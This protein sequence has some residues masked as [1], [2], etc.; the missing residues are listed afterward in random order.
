MYEL[1]DALGQTEIIDSILDIIKNEEKKYFLL[2]GESGCGKSYL[3]QKLTQKWIKNNPSNSALLFKGDNSFSERYYYPFLNCTLL[4][5]ITFAKKTE[6][7]Q[8]IVEVVKDVPLIGNSLSYVASALAKSSKKVKYESALLFNQTE[9]DIFFKLQYYAQRGKLL[10]VADNFHW[11]D[12]QSISFLKLLCSEE[13][14][15]IYSFLKDTIILIIITSNQEK[16]SYKAINDFINIFIKK[17]FVLKSIE[18]EK[19]EFLLRSFGLEKKISPNILS[20]LFT[21]TGGHLEFIKNLVDYINKN[22]NNNFEGF[23]TLVDADIYKEKILEERL[24]LYGATGEQIMDLLEIASIIGLSFD[25][26]EL[27]CITKKNKSF[28]NNIISKSNELSITK[29]DEGKIFFRHEIFKTFFLCKLNNKKSEYYKKFAECLRILRPGDYNS[30]AKYLFDAGDIEDSLVYY[31]AGYLKI[32]RDGKN[33]QESA[34]RIDIVSKEYGLNEYFKS[35]V[36]AYNSFNKRKYE[37]TIQN[38]KKIED[39]YPKLLLVEKDYLLSICYSKSIDISKRIE[40]KNILSI[41][42][43]DKIKLMEGEVWTR[44]MSTLIILNIH[45]NDYYEAR[46]LEKILLIFLVERKKYDPLVHDAI[47]I[48]RRKANALYS[49]EISAQRTKMSIEHFK[50]TDDYGEIKNPIQYYMAM[51]NH[52]GNLILC[53]EFKEA[54]FYSNEAIDFLNKSENIEFPR[55]EIPINNFIISGF[56]SGNLSAKDG[57]TIYEKN[58]T[59]TFAVIMLIVFYY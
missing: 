1:E 55:P 11:W 19:Y 51:A 32:L 27:E 42:I 20:I 7:K 56:L 38:L 45:L 46:K 30:R 36:E 40:A 4:K 53:G 58:L 13:T 29:I 18:F 9:L 48:I 37:E 41:W 59:K 43:N 57:I 49:A 26:A 22:N 10:L 23:N 54:N 15:N 6:T 21:Q 34:V 52:S 12:E 5:N 28:L 3:S 44:V 39:F 2:E 31:I 33:N 25:Y 47:N 35:M 16:V 17:K 14:R 50:S 24:K 8:A